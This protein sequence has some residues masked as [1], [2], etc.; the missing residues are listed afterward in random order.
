MANVYDYPSMPSAELEPY[1]GCSSCTPYWDH[2]DSL[3]E[4]RPLPPDAV[5]A[6]DPGGI[7][8]NYYY[9]GYDY[10]GGNR[11]ERRTIVR[12]L[13]RSITDRIPLELFEHILRSLQYETEDLYNC[14]LVCRAWHHLS[15][16]LLYSRVVIGGRAA[17]D[18]V[19]QC[20][21]QNGWSRKY[22]TRAHTLYIAPDRQ[23]G[24]YGL[25][26]PP[27]LGRR[28]RSLKC[29]EYFGGIQ[30]PYHSS[31]I[32]SFSGFSALIHL[33]LENFTLNSFSDLRSIICGLKNLR[34]LDLVHG[35]LIPSSR[36]TNLSSGFPPVKA[37][38]LS[39]VTLDAL[40]DI[41]FSKL[42]QWMASTDLCYG[43][44]SLSLWVINQQEGRAIVQKLGSSLT[45]LGLRYSESW[46]DLSAL[47]CCTRLSTVLLR[48][49]A[50]SWQEF[51]TALHGMLFH[52]S[53]PVMRTIRAEISMQAP[54]DS[55]FTSGHPDS[56][57][58][59]IDLGSV[60]P[61][62]EKPI[63]DSLQDASIH[64]LWHSPTTRLTCD[65][66]LPAEETER[67]LRLI[68]EPWD[69]RGILTVRGCT[70]EKHRRVDA[71]YYCKPEEESLGGG[72]E[73]AQH[74]NDET[75]F[76]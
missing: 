65:A 39:K 27:V 2:L 35:R 16:I 33:T 14:A 21:L 58:G 30:P 12:P 15:Q 34:E 69:K 71:K 62:L 57:F 8:W 50:S 51:V 67:R 26:I 13:P 43:C 6:V 41:L 55:H 74:P 31:F 49:E 70:D 68:F 66:V 72:S 24:R 54:K 61:L 18:A 28:M 63:F 59:A 42:A 44:T 19:T 11:T 17:Y 4:L 45:S 75:V 36:D 23:L 25:S 46:R 52:L 47:A 10:L 56:E 20:S 9:W 29:L 76:G 22:L 37:P 5:L 3:E 73:E 60:H 1:K 48:T 40:Q 64:V 7:D 38:H 32:H 53:S